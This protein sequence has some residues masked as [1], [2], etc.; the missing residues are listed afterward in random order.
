MGEKQM[1]YAVCVY[2]LSRGRQEKGEKR[3]KSQ[4]KLL[5]VFYFQYL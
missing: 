4:L 5:I 1:Q 2:T 3:E